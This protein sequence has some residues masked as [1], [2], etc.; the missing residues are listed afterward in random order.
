MLLASD[1]KGKMLGRSF[2]LAVLSNLDR[3]AGLDEIEVTDPIG[4]VREEYA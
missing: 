3:R 1:K 4:F 2:W